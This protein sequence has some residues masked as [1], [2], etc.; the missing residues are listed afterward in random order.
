M[1]CRKCAKKIEYDKQYCDECAVEVMKR[2]GTPYGL[3]GFILSLVGIQTGG[4][5]TILGLIF[6]AIHLKKGEFEHRN[7]AKIG[8]ILSIVNLVLIVGS[9]IL[10]IIGY[11][12]L[13]ALL[14]TLRAFTIL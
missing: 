10:V 4:I 14:N 2:S 12:W 6:C 1:I 13:F 8:L 5:C 7:L 9:I 11:S 3:I